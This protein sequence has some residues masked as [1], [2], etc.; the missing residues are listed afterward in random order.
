MDEEV[1][2]LMALAAGAGGGVWYLTRPDRSALQ[3]QTA[4]VTRGI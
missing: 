4:V 1:L 3:F 2:G